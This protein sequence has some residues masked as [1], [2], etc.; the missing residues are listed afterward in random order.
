[1]QDGH[2]SSRGDLSD[3][4]HVMFDDNQSVRTGETQKQFSR[5]GGFLI[6]HAGGGFID[7]QQPRLLGKDDGSSLDP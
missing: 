4:D 2:L 6:R 1:M 3:E 7:E 5:P